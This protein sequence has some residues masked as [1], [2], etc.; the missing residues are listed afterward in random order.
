MSLDR[1]STRESQSALPGP[2]IALRE[3][4]LSAIANLFRNTLYLLST[5]LMVEI[6]LSEEGYDEIILAAAGS[7]VR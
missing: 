3:Y 4:L 1:T 7:S 5:F 6:F 2:H